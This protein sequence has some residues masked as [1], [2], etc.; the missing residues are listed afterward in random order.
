MW[1]NCEQ[2]LFNNAHFFK[3]SEK[4]IVLDVMAT[5]IPG[6]IEKFGTEGEKAFYKFLDGVAKPDAHSLCWYTPDVNGWVI[7]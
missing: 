5:M 7:G 3:L 2:V 6:D 1:K 4:L